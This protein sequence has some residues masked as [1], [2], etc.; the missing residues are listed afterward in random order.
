MD[1]IEAMQIFVQIVEKGSFTA[2]ADQLLLHRPVVTR[3][4]QRLEHELGVRLINRTTRKISIT[5]EGEDFYQ[6]ALQLLA[7]MDDAFANYSSSKQT[8]KGR[9]KISLAATL[10]K[11]IVIPAL[12]DFL[13]NYPQIE[14]H[15]G[16]T[17]QPIDLVDE[18]IDCVVRLG[19]LQDSSA[20]AKR[21]GHVGM[22]TCAART[23]IERHGMPMS[24]E[25]LATHKAINFASGRNRRLV[26]WTFIDNHEESRIKLTSA[27]VTDNSDALLAC[28]LAGMGIIQGVR[29]ALQPYLDSGRLVEV[30]PD[31]PASPKAISIMYPHRIHQPNKT[32]AFIDWLTELL[33]NNKSI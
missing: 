30:L 28:A 27:L 4:I 17:D 18:G 21:I 14:V 5:D 23:Y 10:A 16:V 25:E 2:A 32:S 8:A 31:L 13:H 26:D 24:L 15:L 6:R 19:E 7:S 33:Q 20:I 29:A 12:P 9:L 3:T 22:V 11:S 1:R